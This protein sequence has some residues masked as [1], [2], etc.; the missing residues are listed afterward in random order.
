MDRSS[1]RSIFQTR[2]GPSWLRIAANSGW[3]EDALNESNYGGPAPIDDAGAQ[4][5]ARPLRAPTVVRLDIVTSAEASFPKMST[6][7]TAILPRPCRARVTLVGT[8]LG[9]LP[10]PR[11][12]CQRLRNVVPS[13]S[14]SIA[15]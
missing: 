4:P 15:Q 5:V 12:A 9:F 7:R 10:L 11:N 3:S 2:Q 13:K 14:V 1:R 6:S 8:I